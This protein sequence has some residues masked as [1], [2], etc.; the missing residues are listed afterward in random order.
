MLKKSVWKTKTYH[1][2]RKVLPAVR[3]SSRDGW[4]IGWEIE[5][6][7]VGDGAGVCDSGEA[8]AR[9]MRRVN[10]N[11]ERQRNRNDMIRIA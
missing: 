10:R 8:T 5:D 7:C 11:D 4:W 9:T 1:C 3:M 2:M 6:G